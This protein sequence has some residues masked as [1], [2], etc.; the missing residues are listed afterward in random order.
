[1]LRLNHPRFNT[2]GAW[3]QERPKRQQSATGHIRLTL[4]LHP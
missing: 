1:M 4:Q 2:T 3:P